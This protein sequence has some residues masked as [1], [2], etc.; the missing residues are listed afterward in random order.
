MKRNERSREKRLVKRGQ[1]Q[2]RRMK[3]KEG[4]KEKRSKKY[5]GKEKITHCHEHCYAAK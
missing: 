5:E 4:N 2:E 1:G 3:R